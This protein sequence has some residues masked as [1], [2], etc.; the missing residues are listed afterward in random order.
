MPYKNGKWVDYSK[1]FR[2]DQPVERKENKGLKRLIN[3][4]KKK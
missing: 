4:R 3:K 2:N 1:K